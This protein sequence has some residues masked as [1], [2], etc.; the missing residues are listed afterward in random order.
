MDNNTPTAKPESELLPCP[1]CGH[2]AIGFYD[3]SSDYKAHHDYGVSCQAWLDKENPRCGV[4]V[5]GYKTKEQ[6]Y[7]AWNTRHDSRAEVLAEVLEE[8]E[9]L[10]GQIIDDGENSY[11]ALL[12][13]D[14]KLIIQKAKEQR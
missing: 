7:A 9:K 8:A 13:V 4:S 11:P 5:C 6:A 3:D 1:F 12:L 14:L 2:W 10:A